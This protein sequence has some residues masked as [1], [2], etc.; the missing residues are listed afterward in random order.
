MLGDASELRNLLE[1]VVEDLGYEL[2]LI[3]LAGNRT[4]VLRLYIDA[5]GG[6]LLDDCEQVSRNVSA[7]L[8]VEDPISGQYTLEVSSPGI[9]RP[10]VKP[11]HFQRFV[12]ER[13]KV[14][15]M[16]HHMGR[17]R[18]TGQLVAAQDQDDDEA[19]I[20]VEVDGEPYQFTYD[21]I[22]NARLDPVLG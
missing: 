21:E 20:V 19:G 15:L 4:K 9:D 1:P 16:S 14:K 12:G 17:K 22:D 10:L 5:P 13:V 6:V 18:F 8:D 2:V 3:E 11:E 7:Y